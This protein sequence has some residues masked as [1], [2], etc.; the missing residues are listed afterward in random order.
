LDR[1]TSTGDWRERPALVLLAGNASSRSIEHDAPQQAMTFDLPQV[2]TFAE[3]RDM[4]VRELLI[5]C[6]DYNSRTL[7][8]RCGA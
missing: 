6:S 3:M 5:Y 8:D 1:P 7:N 4:G 2:F